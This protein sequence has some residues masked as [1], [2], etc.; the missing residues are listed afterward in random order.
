MTSR[1]ISLFLLV[2]I[3]HSALKSISFKASS[4]P[5]VAASAKVSPQASVT[6]ATPGNF[7]GFTDSFKNEMASLLSQVTSAS[8][9]GTTIYKDKLLIGLISIDN[10]LA[11]INKNKQREE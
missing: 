2:L 11:L 3:A 10:T 6:K 4:P 8:D 1:L 5:A 7:T 9:P